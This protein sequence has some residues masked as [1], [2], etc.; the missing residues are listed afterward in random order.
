MKEY[1]A[2]PFCKDD[3]FDLMGLKYH[4]RMYC[5]GYVSTPD[6]NDSKVL[7]ENVVQK[8]SDEWVWLRNGVW[9]PMTVEDQIAWT[10]RN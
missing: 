6:I 3:D 7:N 2:C 5:D 1:V 8:S 4:I 10:R 9:V